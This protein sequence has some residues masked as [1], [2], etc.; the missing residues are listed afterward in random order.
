LLERIIHDK[1]LR[2]LSANGLISQHQHGFLAKHSTCTQI[3]ET[4]NDWSIALL[5]RH[6]VDVVYFDFAKAFDSVSHTKLMCKLQAYGFDGA[7]LAFLYEFVTGRSQ[8]VVFPN[9]HSSVMPVTSG[10]GLPQGSVL[11]PLLFLL[12]VN[13]ITDY[14]T[15]SISIKMFADDIKISMMLTFSTVALI[16]LL[17]RPANGN[18]S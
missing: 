4:V 16:V 12:F 9:S 7:L 18:S 8:K 13:D 17:I 5:N 11:G 2:Y 1:M 10:V 3:L 6:V 15:N 14:F